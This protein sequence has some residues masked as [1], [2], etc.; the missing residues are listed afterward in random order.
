[1]DGDGIEDLVSGS[2]KG[3]IHFFRGLGKREFG[4]GKVIVEPG[5]DDADPTHEGCSVLLSSSP[6]ATDWDGD[7]D[8]DL[9]VGQFFGKVFLLSNNGTRK[10]PKFADPV[11]ILAGGESLQ[12]WLLKAGPCVADW[13][14]DGL[15][16]LVVGHERGVHWCR[17]TGTAT[18]P[19]FAEPEAITPSAWEG[20]RFKPCVTDWNGDGLADLLVGSTF[21]QEKAG[22][23]YGKARG[24]VW[25]ALREKGTATAK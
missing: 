1:M 16:D 2:W 11:E 6:W 18:A 4:A 19:K 13:D 5:A 9:V 24:L 21:S 20:Y 15:R 25:L 22:G 3:D 23:S 8:T 17:N 10:E 7:G 12:T 14:G